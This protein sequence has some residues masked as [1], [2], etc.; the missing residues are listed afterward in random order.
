[1]TRAE[2]LLEQYR[3]GV[4]TPQEFVEGVWKYIQTWVR[5]L[6]SYGTD[7]FNVGIFLTAKAV[8]WCDKLFRCFQVDVDKE[9]EVWLTAAAFTED[10][11]LWLYA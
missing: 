5:D 2:Q 11:F 3:A 9:S 1:M 4:I 7:Q 8:H 10:R 6:D